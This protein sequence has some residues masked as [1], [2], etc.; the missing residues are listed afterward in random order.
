MSEINRR[1]FIGTTTMGAALLPSALAA[2]QKFPKGKAEHCVFIWLGGGSCHV[3]TWDPKRKGDAK[4]KKAGSYYNAIDT[5]IPDVQV[6]EHLKQCAGLMEHFSL[7]RTVN[8]NVIDEHAAATNRMHTGRPTSGTI[9]YPSIGS[10]V[11]HERGKVVNGAPAYVVMGYPNLTRGPGFLGAKHGYVYLT[12]TESGPAGLTRPMEITSARQSN[13]DRLLNKLRGDYLKRN[14]NDAKI[15]GYNA[16]ITEAQSLA[17]GEFMSAF[18]LKSEPANLRNAYGGEFGQRCLLARKLIQRGARFLEV[19]FNLNFIN[20]T[21][22]DTHNDGQLKQHILIQQLDQ[23]LATLVKDLKNH[24][25]LDKTLIVVASEFGRP[26]EF[27]AGGGRG[28][29]SKA[30]SVALA[31]G[32]LSNGR[33]VGV[34]DHLGKAIL[35]KPISVPDLFAT[36]HCALGINPHKNLYAGERPVPITDHGQ[37]LREL[38]V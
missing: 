1:K 16:T 20:G 27:D 17:G 36:I 35:E 31:G 21:G 3:D 24:K 19:S 30:F 6:C 8:H 37:P 15:A 33:A 7:L 22:W 12:D 4:L 13:R 23:A 18:D 34:T 5:N 32:G 28:H 9:V 26:P 2:P 38:F 25:L 11:A 14:A 29:Y 10:V